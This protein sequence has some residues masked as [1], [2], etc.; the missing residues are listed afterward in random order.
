M[1][2]RRVLTAFGSSDHGRLGLGAVPGSLIPQVLASLCR[3]SIF[4]VRCGGAHTAAVSDDGS[5]YT[6]GLNDFGQ[7]GHSQ[8]DAY[9]QASRQNCA[10]VCQAMQVRLHSGPSIHAE[11]QRLHWLALVNRTHVPVEIN[12]GLL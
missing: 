12:S 6:W 7:L 1:T 10:P 11:Y 9:A 2:A 5:L 8:D 3:E 4:D